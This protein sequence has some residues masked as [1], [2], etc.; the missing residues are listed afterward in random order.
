M[1]E[2]TKAMCLVT[3]YCNN[4]ALMELVSDNKRVPEHTAKNLVKSILLAVNYCH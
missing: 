4:G 2:S 3:E 1:V